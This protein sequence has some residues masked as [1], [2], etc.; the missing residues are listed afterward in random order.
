M[1]IFWHKGI[2]IILKTTL[3]RHLPQDKERVFVWMGKKPD[4]WE[5]GTRQ[6][7]LITIMPIKMNVAA[8]YC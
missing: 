8:V 7:K 4:R 5:K 3:Q 2:G 6:I 1:F